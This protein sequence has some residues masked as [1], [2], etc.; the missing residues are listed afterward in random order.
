MGIYANG[1]VIIFGIKRFNNDRVG[2]AYGD[3]D[4][5]MDVQIILGTH[6]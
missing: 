1:I 5:A 4:P 2:S 6:Y 3:G